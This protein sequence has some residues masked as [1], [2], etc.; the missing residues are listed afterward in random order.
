MKQTK[1]LLAILCVCLGALAVGC[2]SAD[3]TNTATETAEAVEGAE[4][5]EV[6]EGETVTE[7]ET[8]TTEAN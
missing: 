4:N 3:T 2:G 5:A 1:K 8:E 7:T 6:T